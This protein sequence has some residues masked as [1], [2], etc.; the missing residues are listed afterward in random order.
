[1][2][3]LLRWNAALDTRS[4]NGFMHGKY[5]S[6]SWSEDRTN[7]RKRC[8]GE[9][10]SLLGEQLDGFLGALLSESGWP[11]S[12]GAQT[13]TLVVY[14]WRAS[15]SLRVTPRLR[16]VHRDTVDC[17]KVHSVEKKNDGV[18][19][20][21]PTFTTVFSCLLRAAGAA[22]APSSTHAQ[23]SG[24]LWLSPLQPSLKMLL[25]RGKI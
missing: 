24:L 6:M 19:S 7:W 4:S 10:G 23:W 8:G 22:L 21:V 1:M 17:R 18:A 11:D 14:R 5:N 2:S 16:F 20:L 15:S 9:M 12:R 13:V 25:R 3:S